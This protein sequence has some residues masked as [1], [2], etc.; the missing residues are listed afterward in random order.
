MADVDEQLGR[1]RAAFHA[2]WHE[3]ARGAR[4][5]APMVAERLRP[6]LADL[7]HE[8]SDTA[9]L[10]RRILADRPAGSP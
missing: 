2:A 9:S 4:G 1:R 10:P 3:A 6:L 5:G 7:L 8:C